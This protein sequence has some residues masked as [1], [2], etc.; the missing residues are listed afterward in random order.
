MFYLLGFFLKS[1]IE[2]QFTQLG[3]DFFYTHCG[4]YQS[5]PLNPNFT[6]VT[7]SEI[8]NSLSQ[9]PFLFSLII[10]N[11]YFQ[12]SHIDALC[13]K[14]G[15][16][17]HPLSL[18]ISILGGIIKF[19]RYC[20]LLIWFLESGVRDRSLQYMPLHIA[21]CYRNFNLMEIHIQ[22]A[23]YS[24]YL[25]Y[26]TSSSKVSPSQIT[27]KIGYFQKSIQLLFYVSTDT[28]PVR[29]AIISLL[30]HFHSLLT[31]LGFYSSSP[32]VHSHHLTE[33]SFKK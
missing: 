11:Y 12:Q 14:R 4:A 16:E 31:C 6:L 28:N 13:K 17:R 25:S 24:F 20:Y 5:L 22:I 9:L 27:L 10:F 15:R 32:A 26:L 1:L 3:R 7:T 29:A 8:F 23:Q 18:F 19:Y 30:V 2:V 21:F 33:W